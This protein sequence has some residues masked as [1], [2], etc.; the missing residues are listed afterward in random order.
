MSDRLLDFSISQDSLTLIHTRNRHYTHIIG[1]IILNFI[2]L[3]TFSIIQGYILMSH[4]DWDAI[5]VLIF[6]CITIILEGLSLLQIF[7]MQTD[8][9]VITTSFIIMTETLILGISIYQTTTEEFE[10][11]S[12]FEIFVQVIAIILFFLIAILKLILV[13]QLKKV[14]DL[15]RATNQIKEGMRS[16]QAYEN[17]SKTLK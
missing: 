14:L 17:F 15:T 6:A 4:Q 7:H 5:A 1:S 16:K 13:I 11:D 8:K 9:L 3:L 12:K 10:Q 2:T